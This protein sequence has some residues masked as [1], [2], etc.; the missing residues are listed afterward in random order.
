MNALGA[1]WA[2]QWNCGI[3]EIDD[4]PGQIPVYHIARMFGMAKAFDMHDYGK[5]RYN[6]LG[7]GGHWFAGAKAG[8]ET[9]WPALRQRLA[10]HPLAAR[11]VAA[12]REA[13]ALFNAED[14]KRLSESE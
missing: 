13:H 6:L 1:D 12:I 5:M 10:H 4:T 11:L 2:A 14:Q 7:N 8:D 9:D 3:P